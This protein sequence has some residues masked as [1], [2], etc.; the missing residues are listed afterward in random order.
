LIPTPASTVPS[1]ENAKDSSAS[2]LASNRRAR[3]DSISKRMAPWVLSAAA[4]Y[5]PSLEVATR[6]SGRGTWPSGLGR[7]CAGLFE[8]QGWSW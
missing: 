5:L 4:R 3:P 7:V 8:V 2:P 6:D 1:G